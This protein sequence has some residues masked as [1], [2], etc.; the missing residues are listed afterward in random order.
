VLKKANDLQTEADV[1]ATLIG[2]LAAK[3]DERFTHPGSGSTSTPSSRR[4][5]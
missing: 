2:F 5:A 3:P 1:P 4:V